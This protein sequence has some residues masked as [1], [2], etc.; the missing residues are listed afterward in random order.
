MVYQVVA[1]LLAKHQPLFSLLQHFSPFSS[2]FKAGIT[3]VGG[4]V[5][6][7]CAQC[8]WVCV[9]LCVCVCVGLCVC[10]NRNCIQGS[11][12]L[13]M[14]PPNMFICMSIVFSFYCV[15]VCVSV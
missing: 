1:L 14:T 7:V 15:C 2:C 13:T 6:G 3:C 9:C 12:P 5:T 8:V 4:C 10:V 11:S